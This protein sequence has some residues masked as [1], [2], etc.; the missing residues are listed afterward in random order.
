MDGLPRLP[1]S[2]G[3]RKVRLGATAVKREGPPLETLTYRLAECPAEFLAE[4]RIGS[5]GTVHLAAVV[6]DLLRDLGGPP[7]SAEAASDFQ[8]RNPKADR[9]RFKLTLLT[10]WLLHDPWF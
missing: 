1:Q 4:P 6:S 9:N 8:S 10:C 2:S 5:A 7:M 3:V